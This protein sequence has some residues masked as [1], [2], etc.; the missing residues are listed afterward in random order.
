MCSTYASHLPGTE[1]P[2]TYPVIHK[3]KTFGL[4]KIIRNVALSVRTTKHLIRIPNKRSP[5]DIRMQ[6][7]RGGGGTAP[8][9][10]HPA[11]EGGGWS[12]ARSGRFDLRKDPVITALEAGLASGS[13]RTAQK[14]S[15]HRDSIPE[16]SIPCR[17]AIPT[18][19]TQQISP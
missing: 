7:E 12:A 11:L 2:E 9:I 1:S 19:L 6:T 5:H 17:V 16:P 18:S 4:D 14:I 3:R 15:P 8:T 13:V 10:R